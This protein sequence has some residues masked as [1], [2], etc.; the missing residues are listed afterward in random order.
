MWQRDVLWQ[1]DVLFATWG[2]IVGRFACFITK[3][4]LR[5]E[6]EDNHSVSL[7][8]VYCR[9]EKDP[10]GITLKIFFLNL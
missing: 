9:M 5:E 3:R 7:S 6:K 8:S 2:V 4:L 1:G 10:E